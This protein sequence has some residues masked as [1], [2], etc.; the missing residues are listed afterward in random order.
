MA[1]VTYAA[2]HD[3]DFSMMIREIISINLDHIEN[4]VVD[5]VRPQHT[6]PHLT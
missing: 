4:D 5:I 6:G 2:T 1:K 3:Y